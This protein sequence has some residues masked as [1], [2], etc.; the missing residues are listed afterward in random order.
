MRY[1]VYVLK[2]KKGGRLYKGLTQDLIKRISQDN[3]GENKS[4]KGFIPW[5]LYHYEIFE[6]RVEARSREKYFKSGSGR[7]FLRALYDKGTFN[8]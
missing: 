1:Y 5:E 6:T 7:E 3:N 4:T 2:S 8:D